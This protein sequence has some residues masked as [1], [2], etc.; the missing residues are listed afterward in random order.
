MQ[1][2]RGV[3]TLPL[4]LSSNRSVI[5]KWWVDALF[6][7]HP[8]I[9]VH[10]IGGLSLGRGFPIVRSTKQNLNT[11]IPTETEIVGVDDSMPEI[12]WTRYFISAQGYNSKDNRLHHYNK[13]SI[14]M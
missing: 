7:V 8:N 5:F 6:A 11:K 2:I 1:Y 4:T 9:Q 3:R 12:C 13:F 14:I 10:Y